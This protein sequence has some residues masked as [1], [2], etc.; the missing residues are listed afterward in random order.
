MSSVATKV[1]VTRLLVLHMKSSYRRAPL[2][3]YEMFDIA[4]EDEAS[5]TLA[6]PNEFSAKQMLG[7]PQ[8]R[9]SAIQ[10]I[11]KADVNEVHYVQVFSC[12]DGKT[13]WHFDV[14]VYA[15]MDEGSDQEHYI[16]YWSAEISKRAMQELKDQNQMLKQMYKEIEA[17]S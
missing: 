10:N 6:I 15:E 2:L 4:V 13:Y 9:S 8:V 7:G 5:Y 1:K 14:Y 16:E 17:I 11:K 12:V 3:D